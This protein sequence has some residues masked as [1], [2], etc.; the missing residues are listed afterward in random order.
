MVHVFSC[1]NTDNVN[2]KNYYEQFWS[3]TTPCLQ[4]ITLG[5]RDEF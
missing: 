2:Q 4:A 5:L 1:T 3:I